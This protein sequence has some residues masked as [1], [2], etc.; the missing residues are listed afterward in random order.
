MNISTESDKLA[1]T[2][3]VAIVIGRRGPAGSTESEARRPGG[4]AA[5]RPGGPGGRA[6][7]G[8]GRPGG[9]GRGAGGPGSHDHGN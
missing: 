5:G 9:R 6:A 1:E 7:G 8:A 2:L 4:R 3:P